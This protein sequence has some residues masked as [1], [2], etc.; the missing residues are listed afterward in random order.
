MSVVAAYARAPADLCETARASEGTMARACVDCG[1]KPW[2]HAA[3]GWDAPPPKAP[4]RYRLPAPSNTLVG[5]PLTSAQPI[6]QVPD[7]PYFR[8][9]PGKTAFKVAATRVLTNGLSSSLV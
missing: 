1:G 3:L 2:R 5:H 7:Q 4:P 9:P 8:P 6:G